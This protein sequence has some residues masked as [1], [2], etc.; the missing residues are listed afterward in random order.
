[1]GEDHNDEYF[2][3]GKPPNMSTYPTRDAEI[4]RL[5]AQLAALEAKLAE[6]EAK[7]IEAE[8]GWPAERRRLDAEKRLERRN[9]ETLRA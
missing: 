6:S 2:T 5:N 1:M 4:V 3:I 9:I 7:R 8:G